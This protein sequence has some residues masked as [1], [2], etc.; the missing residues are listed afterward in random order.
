MTGN[1]SPKYGSLDPNKPY[2]RFPAILLS[3]ALIRPNAQGR[4]HYSLASTF[5]S[6]RCS[7]SLTHHIIHN[8][9]NHAY[10]AES[11]QDRH[12]RIRPPDAIHG[13]HQSWHLHRNRQIRQQVLRELGTRVTPSVPPSASF[14]SHPPTVANCTLADRSNQYERDGSTTSKKNTTPHRLSQGGTRGCRTWSTSHRPR[15]RC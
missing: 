13:R 11:P 3:G 8:V 5:T 1:A 7:A 6:T 2:R 4:G 15:T 12:K 9:D 14:F 10:P